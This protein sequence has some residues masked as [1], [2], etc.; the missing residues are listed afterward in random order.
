MIIGDIY[1]YDIL[2]ENIIQSRLDSYLWIS[3]NN[4]WRF[5]FYSKSILTFSQMIEYQASSWQLVRGVGIDKIF[6][7]Q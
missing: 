4:I 3:K 2:Y 7:I 6:I 5:L 1:Y